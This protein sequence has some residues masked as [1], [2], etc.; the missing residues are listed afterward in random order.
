MSRERPSTSTRRPPSTGPSGRGRYVFMLTLIV[1][2]LGALVGR[3]VYLNVIDRDFLQNQGDARTLRVEPIKAH[4]GM[5]TDRNGD[6]LAISTP[7]VT[8]WANP[9]E[10]PSDP[11]QL[12]TLAHALN[13]DPETLESRVERYA[14]HEFMYLRRRMT[15]EAAQPALALD[16]PGVYSKDEYKRYYP[17]GAV[18]AQLVGVTNIDDQG[19]EGLELA[20]N[21]YL[22]G[23]P[24]KRRV[25]KDRKGRLVR[26]LHLLKDAKPGGDLTLSID[27]RL[28]YMAY[29]E[30]KKAVDKRNAD[31][32]SL[33]M[34][35]ARSG[36]V[37]AMVN[38]PSYN[39]NNRASIDAAGLRNQAITDAIEPGSVMKPLAMSA[40][41]ATAKIDTDTVIDTSPG[42]MVID[43]YTIS[44]F[45]NYGK[46]TPGG[47]LLHSSN[48]GMSHIALKLDKD[49]IWQQYRELGL[50]QAPGTGFPGEGSGSL[51]SL[52]GL[53]RSAQATMAYGYGISLTPLQLAS[54]YTALANDGRRLRPSL[55]K[56]SSP[57]LGK[58][59]MS[60][61]IAHELL[62]MMEKIVQ[63]GA[64]GS[65][66]MVEG[67]RI[68]G[69][70]GTVRKVTDGGYQ[71]KAY[72][73]LFAGIAPVS[74]PRIVTVVMI[75]HPKGDAYYGGL[76]AAP[77]F[78]R[79]VGKALRL[80]DV[81]PDQQEMSE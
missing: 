73:G 74:D 57:Q 33:V 50:G 25:L 2:A 36:E 7:V 76:V 37:L 54:A 66:A 62:E 19:Q 81:P 30:L 45:R 79:V 21:K 47:I 41:L 44:D 67:Y 70:T 43:G 28:Q 72:R 75:D 24:G 38:L 20:Y 58:Q 39:P 69:K 14:D 53:S 64:G 65:R 32:G 18:T 17:S 52:Y 23:Q 15:P 26:D 60:P 34:M 1:V 9:Q 29:R 71:Q 35:D 77:V 51:P 16:M 10:L 63:P 48:I 12:A 8:L 68:A 61:K 22:S 49:T 55:L 42:W 40:A 59:V 78:G 80:L 31:G 56:R 11:I 46:L 27:L 13:M 4:R 3:I 5:I 6:P